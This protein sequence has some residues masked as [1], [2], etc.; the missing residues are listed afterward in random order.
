[1]NKNDHPYS[2]YGLSEETVLGMSWDAYCYD[3]TTPNFAEPV[4]DGRLMFWLAPYAEGGDE[5]YVDDISLQK[6]DLISDRTLA[7]GS[8]EEQFP[9]RFALKQNYPNP[10]NPSTTIRYA[11]PEGTRQS[12]SLQVF[13]VLGRLVATLVDDLKPAGVHAVQFDGSGLASGVYFY[14]LRAG[15]FVATNRLVLQK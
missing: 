4:G 15:D 3:F 1:M 7:V 12:V 14:R 8:D 9:T 5:Y 10:F 2:G 13:D 11:I 6:I